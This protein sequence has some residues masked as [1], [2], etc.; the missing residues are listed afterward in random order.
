MGGDAEESDRIN[1]FQAIFW[2]ND[3]V[4]VNTEH[5]YF[6]ATQQVLATVDIDLDAETYRD[7]FLKQSQGAWH[8]AAARGISQDRLTALREA[9]NVLYSRL[10]QEADITI[11]GVAPVLQNLTQRFSMGVVTT[12]HRDHFE[13]IH[14]RTAFLPL[15]DFV[16]VREDYGQSKPNPEPYL[17]ALQMS[18]YPPASCLVIEDSE[19]GLTAAKAAGLACWVIP[20][21]LSRSGD[22]SAADKVLE[23]ISQV[24]VYLAEMARGG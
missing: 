7:F 1:M 17:K 24:P 18:G 9:R 11:P 12:S 20:T 19:R 8:L 5:L 10:L 22:F 3:G 15:F 14:R 16:L 23:H 2:D 6:Q 21:G 4:L 13:I